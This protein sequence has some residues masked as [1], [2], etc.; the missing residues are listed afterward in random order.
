VT[1]PVRI[2]RLLRHY[3]HGA[4]RMGR[5]IVGLGNLSDAERGLLAEFEEL[6]RRGLR[7]T[8]AQAA[9]AAELLSRVVVQ[10]RVRMLVSA[11]ENAFTVPQ[12]QEIFLRETANLSERPSVTEWIRT[13]DQTSEAYDILRWLCGDNFRAQAD[14]RQGLG[15]RLFSVFSVPAPAHMLLTPEESI[16][17]LLSI[18]GGSRV[19]FDRLERPLFNVNHRSAGPALLASGRV[20]RGMFSILKGNI[21]ELLARNQVIA[22]LRGDRFMLPPGAVLV[23]GARIRLPGTTRSMLFSDGLVGIIEGD[24][25]RWLGAVEVKGYDAGFRDGVA[26][27]TRWRDVSEFTSGFTLEFRRGTTLTSIAEL[28]APLRF[29]FDPA[30]AANEVVRD[31]AG[32]RHL[33]VAPRGASRFDLSAASGSVPDGIIQ[34]TH[35]VA[36]DAIDHVAAVVLQTVSGQTTVAGA[37]SALR[38]FAEMF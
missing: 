20:S 8:A 5:I 26:Q 1:F 32:I 14:L 2:T 13:I 27:V 28:T 37:E 34:I 10:Y 33:V 6:V 38:S 17:D 24:R 16:R 15:S 3:G 9:H 7:L 35:P 25:W 19:I 4:A 30:S 36:T 31:A 12:L 18:P 22:V 23:S 21:A 11:S 29:G